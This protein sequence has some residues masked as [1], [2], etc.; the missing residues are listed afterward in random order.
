MSLLCEEGDSWADEWGVLDHDVGDDRV[1]VL[2][3]GV[4][5]GLQWGLLFSFPEE[6]LFLRVLCGGRCYQNLLTIQY[7]QSP[8]DPRRGEYIWGQCNGKHLR[9]LH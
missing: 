9:P 2:L 6:D 1:P 4:G 5:R 8:W 7:T 3:F